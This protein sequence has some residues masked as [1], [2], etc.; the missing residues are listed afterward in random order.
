MEELLN[1]E[2]YLSGTT[3]IGR[4]DISLSGVPHATLK[5]HEILAMLRE[6]NWKLFVELRGLYKKSIRIYVAVNIVNIMA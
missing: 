1:N 3:D 2:Q 6:W 5:Y 4:N